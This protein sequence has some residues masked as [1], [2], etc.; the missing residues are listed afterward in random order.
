MFYLFIQHII[1]TIGS[2]D[3]L[4]E[5][6]SKLINKLEE[7][8]NLI[9]HSNY[10]LWEQEKTLGEEFTCLLGGTPSTKKNE[11]WNGDISWINSGEVNNLRIF[12]ASKYI[13]RLGLEKS[14]T[15]LLPKGTT[16][17]A[18][19]GATLG[20][21]SL[22]EIA[23]CANQSVI[24]ILENEYYKRD[25]IY[26]L[27]KHIISELTLKQ[28]GGAQ[29]H[30]NKNDV[31]T[32]IIKLPN[33]EEYKKYSQLVLP[34]INYQSILVEENNKLNLLKQQYLKKFFG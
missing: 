11:Y 13:T 24:G 23:S 17:I 19:T 34:L 20:Q 10:K 18:I 14:A 28:T 30:I 27:L 4:I 16:V 12:K 25:Y 29:Q 21:V 15:K 33:E 26:P 2:I 31:E 22:L 5:I 32:F 3:D 7:K 8:I 9:F 6:N 1:N